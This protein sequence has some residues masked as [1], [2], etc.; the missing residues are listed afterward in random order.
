MKFD[1]FAVGQVFGT[2]S[3]KI[4]K[5]EIKRFAQEFDPLHLHVDEKK[6]A[7][8]GYNG[9]IASGIHTLG[10]SYKLWVEQGIFGDDI[11]AGRGMNNIKFIKPVYPNDVL[12]TV[13]EVIGKKKINSEKGIITISLSAYNGKEEKVFE[14]DLSV[15][16]KR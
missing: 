12:H 13:V 4:T 3:Y 6:A 5:E 8:G 14:G 1:Q 11:I 7:Q 16:I 15:I 10:I 9:I 2:S